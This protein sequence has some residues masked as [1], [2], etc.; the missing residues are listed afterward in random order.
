MFNEV[1]DVIGN[2]VGWGAGAALALLGIVFLSKAIKIV[3]AQTALVIERLGKYHVTLHAGL[4]LIVPFFDRVRY[5]HSLKERAIDVPI[6]PCITRDNIRVEVDGI[7]YLKVVDP[8]KASYGISKFLYATRLLAQTTM[9]SIFGKM[10]MDKTF[11]EREKINAQ[12]VKA[13]DE[14]SDP[15]GVKVTRYEIKN[16]SVPR[17]ILIVMEVQMEAER[18]KR[19]V[20][21]KSEGEMQSRINYSQGI[22]EEAIQKSEGEMKRLTNEAEGKAKEIEAISKAT[23]LGI[24]KLA[25]AIDEDGGDDAVALRIADEY[26]NQLKYLAREST[27]VVLPLDLG[28]MRSF[29]SM[30]KKSLVE[31]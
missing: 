7:L 18:V 26:I 15:W 22:Q 6:Q 14:A 29:I 30:F 9:R 20:I 16:I 24:T 19:A 21:A 4:Q 13:V 1:M 12:V 23:A 10:D 17:E 5:K 11:E 27:E 31:E 8:R 2:I 3:P 28:D 25:E